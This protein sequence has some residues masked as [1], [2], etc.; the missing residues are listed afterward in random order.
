MPAPWNSC[1]TKR[2]I[3]RLCHNTHNTLS[4]CLS[5]LPFLFP[6]FL[7]SFFPSFRPSVLPSFRP[8]F[9]PSFCQTVVSTSRAQTSLVFLQFLALEFLLAVLSF[10]AALLRKRFFELRALR[11]LVPAASTVVG[12]FFGNVAGLA[13]LG[14]LVLPTTMYSKCR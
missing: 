9:L 4:S 10:S 8:F 3:H 14:S 11:I 7:P 13:C 2:Y 12:G 5:F 6:S 1:T